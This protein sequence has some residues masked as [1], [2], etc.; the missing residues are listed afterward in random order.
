MLKHVLALYLQKK[1]ISD[2]FLFLQL[3][4]VPRAKYLF[5]YNISRLVSLKIWQQIFI[6]FDN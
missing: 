5:C 3:A 4:T 2:S 6:F 1:L